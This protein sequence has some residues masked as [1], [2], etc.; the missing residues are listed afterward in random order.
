[1]VEPAAPSITVEQSYDYMKG[2]RDDDAAYTYNVTQTMNTTSPRIGTVLT[3]AQ[4][5][6]LIKEGN[7]VSIK[8]RS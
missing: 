1:M 5:D 4:V 6:A 2:N 7:R 3:R 8:R